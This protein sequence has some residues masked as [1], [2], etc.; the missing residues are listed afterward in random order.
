MV[1]ASIQFPGHA[2]EERSIEAV[3]APGDAIDGPDEQGV[4]WKVRAIFSNNI[5]GVAEI[6]CKA[7]PAP[8]IVGDAPACPLTS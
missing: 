5:T 8:M 3:P 1:Q 2:V 6:T 7:E 4:I